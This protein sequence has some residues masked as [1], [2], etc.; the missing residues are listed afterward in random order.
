MGVKQADE[1]KQLIAPTTC[2]F[3]KGS[4]R[5]ILCSATSAVAVFSRLPSGSR[6]CV[7]DRELFRIEIVWP[8]TFSKP[9]RLASSF[10]VP[11]KRRTDI[12]RH[13]ADQATASPT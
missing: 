9:E 12:G 6:L 13:V 5:F 7:S 11:S 8:P 4:T 10:P 1:R 3:S 2:S